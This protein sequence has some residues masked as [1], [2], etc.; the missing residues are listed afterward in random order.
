[1]HS[2]SS[3]ESSSSSG[4]IDF[5]EQEC[6][7]SNPGADDYDSEDIPFDNNTGKDVATVEIMS[8]ETAPVIVLGVSS[9]AVTVK[10]KE[11]IDIAGVDFLEVGFQFKG[12]NGEIVGMA[13]INLGVK[14]TA[15]NVVKNAAKAYDYTFELEGDINSTVSNQ[16]T[17]FG[18]NTTQSAQAGLT[19]SAVVNLNN[20]NT[21][22]QMKASAAADIPS[23]DNI[24]VSKKLSG[25]VTWKG[26]SGSYADVSIFGDVSTLFTDK[27][28]QSSLTLGGD[29]KFKNFDTGNKTLNLL[30]NNFKTHIETSHSDKAGARWNPSFMGGISIKF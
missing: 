4:D 27:N 21:S 11:G 6:E 29:I 26:L 5:T 12:N 30:I 15:T 2:S 13:K 14:Q 1:M 28:T 10:A 9:N 7:A 17:G 24:S 19:A 25:T 16:A 23:P 8:P 20:L 22:F 18:F 3:E